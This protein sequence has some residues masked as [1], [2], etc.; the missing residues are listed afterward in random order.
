MAELVK[1]KRRRIWLKVLLAIVVLLSVFAYALTTSPVQTLIAQFFSGVLSEELGTNVEVDKVKIK[2]FNKVTIDGFLMEDLNGDT[3]IYSDRL[4]ASIANFSIRYKYADIE[5][6]HFHNPIV[7][8]TTDSLNQPSYKFLEILSSQDST[9][10]NNWNFII[11]AFVLDNGTFSYKP[12]KSSDKFQY[13]NIDLGISNIVISEDSLLCKLDS[14]S[15][16]DINGFQVRN[17]SGSISANFPTINLKDL[18][19]SSDIADISSNNINIDMSKMNESGKLEDLILDCHID[20][21]TIDFSNLGL[22]IHQRVNSNLRLALQGNIN[23]TLKSLV[24]RNVNI[25]TG[26]QT[27]LNFN[28]KAKDILDY[29]KIYLDFDINRFNVELHDIDGIV[30]PFSKEAI[31][32][33]EPILN[34]GIYK[35]DGNIK[36]YINNFN[37][38]ANLSSKFGKITAELQVTPG[39]SGATFFVGNI[40]T[41]HLDINSLL[42]NKLVDKLTFNGKINGLY[43]SKTDYFSTYVNG[44]IDSF[45]VNNYCLSSINIEG[46]LDKS[47]YEGKIA[48]DDPNLQLSLNGIIDRNNDEQNFD[49]NLN[50]DEAHLDKLNL[51]SSSLLKS[52]A[53]ELDAKIRGSDIYNYFGEINI[54]NG[55]LSSDNNTLLINDI[56]LKRTKGALDNFVVSSPFIDLFMNGTFRFIDIVPTFKKFMA[57]HLPVAAFIQQDSTEASPEINFVMEAHF[58]KLDDI[59]Q[60]ITPKL[61]I[62][63]DFTLKSSMNSHDNTLKIS[64]IIPE[65]AYSDTYLNNININGDI[66]ENNTVGSLS[67]SKIALGSKYEVLNCNATTNIANNNID[68]SLSWKNDEQNKGDIKAHTSFIGTEDS[69]HTHTQSVIPTSEI[70]LLGKK[71]ELSASKIELNKGIADIEAFNFVNTDN[72]HSLSCN[73]RISDKDNEKIDL[74]INNIQVNNALNIFKINT[75]LDGVVNGRLSIWSVLNTPKVSTDIEAHNIEFKEQSIGNLSLNN[76][77]D[78]NTKNITAAIKLINND[79]HI[80]DCDAS[81][82]LGTD[83]LSFDSKIDGF[84]LKLLELVL[85]KVFSSTDGTAYG[86]FNISG[87]VPDIKY[88]GELF[89]NN[90]EL[91]IAATGANYR[92]TDT[93][94]MEGNRIAFRDITA[95][96]KYGDSA[97]VNGYIEH[98]NFNNMIYDIQI[99]TQR[100]CALNSSPS[101]NEVFYGDAFAGGRIRISGTGKDILISGNATTGKGTKLNMG[102]FHKS[103]EE[104]HSFIRFIEPKLDNEVTHE[105]IMSKLNYVSET[106]GVGFNFNITAT[107][108]ASI[109]IFY[110]NS[111]DDEIEAKGDGS[112]KIEMNKYGDFKMAGTYTISDG[113]Y[114]FSLKDLLTKTF[115]IKRGSTMRWSGSPQDA[116][117]NISAIYQIKTSISDLAGGDISTVT[118][119][120]VDCYIV[121]TGQLTSP[122]INFDIKFPTVDAST[123]SILQQY[124]S[125]ADELNRQ[126]L[127]LL[128]LGRFYNNN[129][130]TTGGAGTDFVNNTASELLTSSLSSW[131]S[132]I[133]RNVDIGLRYRP[134]EGEIQDEFEVS[135]STALLNDH[136]LISGNVG[137]TNNAYYLSNANNNIVGEFDISVKLT[138]DGNWLLKAF[139]HA[140]NNFY[141]AAPYTQGVSLTFK[142][143]F[144]LLIKRYNKKYKKEVG[145][146]KKEEE[147]KIKEQ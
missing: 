38:D 116:D 46:N 68:Y 52:T 130:T 79:K 47:R 73:G 122:D 20:N 119:P 60:F 115:K 113:T 135:L 78:S 59:A 39:E 50:V 65:F 24:G 51:V 147:P 26:R 55:Y 132:Q 95:Y 142:H 9:K 129:T 34:G 5:K 76:T 32:I 96:D 83:S 109:K 144:D 31:K 110:F 36:G 138:K 21:S 17:I 99:N 19:L 143:D 41:H 107:P 145:K 90:A 27:T 62:S 2:F 54:N 89:G 98:T 87:K 88:S 57:H 108:D 22:L 71:W 117:V 120:I 53:F 114:K 49:F 100:I 28:F 125:T 18:S 11:G 48:I 91:T 77:W 16:N 56:H 124:L 146:A 44:V 64:T 67:I 118:R 84:P 75:P 40:E 69:L 131:L 23:G 14:L 72:G 6:V 141:D 104:T 80:V 101:Q 13:S 92:F 103:N 3:L 70:F 139:N 97:K 121:L 1:R 66:N 105:T 8:I 35:I 25:S 63:D 102:L 127:S 137:N 134:N 106:S 10:D 82:N 61:H 140:N 112:L 136:I 133:N 58:K 81:Y 7:G 45:Y 93:V 4:D 128:L 94:F 111:L 74:D 30:L 33:S 15:L 37:A 86:H 123:A 43:D 42:N 85:Y 126:A 29:N 12:Y